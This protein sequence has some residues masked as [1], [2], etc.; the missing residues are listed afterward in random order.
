MKAWEELTERGKFRRLRPLAETALREYDLDVRRI[1]FVG[2]FTNVIFR[3]DAD[4]GT[5]ALRIDYMQDHTDVNVAVELEWLAA[6]TAETDIDVARVLPAR[7]GGP[8][9]YAGAPG[10]PAERRC[11][12]FEWIP[13]KPLADGASPERFHQLGVLSAQLRLHGARFKPKHRPMAWDRVFYWNEEFDPVVYDRP[14]HA[15]HFTG[16]RMGV[17]EEALEVAGQAFHRLDQDALQVLHGD[18]HPWNVHVK[19]R[20]MI[21]L[22]FEDVMWAHPVQDVAI[23]LFYGRDDPQYGEQRA[24]FAE[25]YS[26]IAPWPESYPGEIEHFMAARTLMFVNLVLNIGSDIEEFYPGFFKRLEDFLE[27]WG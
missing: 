9:V 13:G 3:V 16:R 1:S 11:V 6:L 24:A 17:M 20:R 2:G 23:T 4:Q 7:D 12:L 27:A 10:V 14:E 25:G 21:A 15:H 22:D 8:F 5:F 18:L 26:A 19:G